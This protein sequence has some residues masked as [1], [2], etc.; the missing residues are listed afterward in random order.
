LLL[1]FSA[2]LVASFVVL[3]LVK[4]MLS[5]ELLYL[6]LTV[7]I[8]L[9]VATAVGIVLLALTGRRGEQSNDC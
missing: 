1:Q 3:L 4:M 9:V 5:R 2:A 7:W 6:Y 8:V